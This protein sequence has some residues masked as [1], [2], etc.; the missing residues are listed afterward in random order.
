MFYNERQKETFLGIKLLNFA[1]FIII[2]FHGYVRRNKWAD[3]QDYLYEIQNSYR[4]IFKY[5]CLQIIS[6]YK[7]I[8]SAKNDWCP[9]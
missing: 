6:N 2:I 3:S 4:C 1:T 5:I 8:I 9:A 7:V